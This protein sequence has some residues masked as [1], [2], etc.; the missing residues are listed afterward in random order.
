M[1]VNCKA[2]YW[3]GTP[4]VVVPRQRAVGAWAGSRTAVES[5]PSRAILRAKWLLC[6]ETPIQFDSAA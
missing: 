3:P 2:I 1:E 5:L 4:I 6:A